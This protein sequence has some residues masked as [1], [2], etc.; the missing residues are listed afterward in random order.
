MISLSVE[1]MRAAMRFRKQEIPFPPA[2]NIRR[3]EF[4]VLSRIEGGP[5]CGADRA[6]VSDIQNRLDFSKPAISQMLSALEAKGLIVREPDKADRRK[7]MVSLTPK[8]REILA[9]AKA[10]MHGLME[11]GIRRFGEE[12]TRKLIELINRLSDVTD[13]IMRENAEKALEGEPRT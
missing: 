1:L 8:G 4:F 10:H 9:N 11:E 5:F 6:S 2:L 3:S 7:V 13:E 12:N